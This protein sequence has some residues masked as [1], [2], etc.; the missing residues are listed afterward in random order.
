MSVAVGVSRALADLLPRGARSA[1][2][3]QKAL[4]LPGMLGGDQLGAYCLS[5][6]QAGSDVASMTTRA[7]P[8]ADGAAYRLKG[9]KA[10]ISHAGHADFYTTFVRTS[11]D[12]EP[13]AVL[14]RRPGGR[15]RHLVRRRPSARWACTATPC[16]R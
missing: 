2:D 12:G 3:E 16:D 15:R 9:T 14:L 13:R 11:D 10:W 4:L 7:T 5:E 6:P 8:E 1:P